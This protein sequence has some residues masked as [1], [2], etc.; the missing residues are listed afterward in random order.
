MLILIAIIAT[1]V[2]VLKKYDPSSHE[3]KKF[4][5]MIGANTTVLL[6]QECFK[7]A[8]E[9]EDL[10]SVF[11]TT[12]STSTDYD[13]IIFLTNY[14]VS[15]VPLLLPQRPLPYSLKGRENFGIN[16]YRNDPIYA[17]GRSLISYSVSITADDDNSTV[18]PVEFYLFDSNNTYREFIHYVDRRIPNY[19]DCFSLC[20]EENRIVEPVQ[21][22]N[23]SVA[24]PGFYFVGGSLQDEVSINVTISA[25]LQVYKYSSHLQP[26]CALNSRNRLCKFN[27]NTSVGAI[28]L[29]ALSRNSYLQNVTMSFNYKYKGITLYGIIIFA[30]IIGMLF[31]II[32]LILIL[33]FIV[34]Q[35]CQNKK[36]AKHF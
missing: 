17:A 26:Q 23:F 16:Y 35:K 32:F 19:N 5:S 13:V 31:C 2:V 33:I 28:C 20:N 21:T 6:Q 9:L 12:E 10:E 30:E 18:C 3:F 22:F 4:S 25:E 8:D 36:A 34:K 29:F 15:K 11:V 27:A 7:S 14:T 1:F 24:R